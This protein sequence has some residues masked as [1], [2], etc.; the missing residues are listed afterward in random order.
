MTRFRSSNLPIALSGIITSLLAIPQT[1]S[2]AIQGDTAAVITGTVRSTQGGQP[3]QAANVRIAALNVS[4]GTS[5]NGFYRINVMRNR[6]QGQVVE[7]SVRAIGHRPET[8]QIRLD[9][10]QR[11]Y[12]FIL[13]V[14]STRASEVV[15]T[16]A[17]GGDSKTLAY[18][19]NRGDSSLTRWIPVT[20]TPF[21]QH[22]IPP[23]LIMQNQ[24][25]LKI[26]EAQRTAIM[27]Q[28][29]KVQ[30]TATQAQWRVA[31]ESEKLNVLLAR[32]DVPEADV[33]AQAERLM[34]WESA[35]K[36]AQ[37]TMLIRI[38]NV[39][40]PEQLTMLREMRRRD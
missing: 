33:L 1:A 17:R 16:D 9:P 19:V 12:D 7:L 5:A 28:I 4:I 31:D 26:T 29:N 34:T 18:T 40:T 2:G 32:D 25:R 23:E 22:L 21:A 13:S 6:V 35:V 8:R 3:L 24:G 11:N 10:G 20:S 27:Q 30:E 36:T 38:R 39:L 14:D 15:V 37:L